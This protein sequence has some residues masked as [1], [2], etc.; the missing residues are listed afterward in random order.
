MVDF[1]ESIGDF[2]IL[3][4]S[5]IIVYNDSEI[6][7]ELR[8][9][10]KPLVLKIYF[11]N[12]GG[13]KSSVLEEVNDNTLSLKFVNFEKENSLGGIF[14]PLRVGILDNG[15][16]LYFNCVIYTLNA[17]EGNRLLKYSF[18]KNRHK[19]QRKAKFYINKCRSASCMQGGLK[20]ASA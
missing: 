6:N 8:E 15:E 17:S 2:T 11:V 3:K 20:Q 1:I 18:L 12:K 9:N 14:E 5:E 19:A 16:I 4:Q 13:R 7:I 10:D